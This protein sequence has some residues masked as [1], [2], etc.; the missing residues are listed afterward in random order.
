MTEGHDRMFSKSYT[1]F[2]YQHKTEFGTI[3]G[4]SE[5]IATWID[6]CP[7]LPIK[8]IRMRNHI[9]CRVAETSLHSLWLFLSSRLTTTFQMGKPKPR[10]LFIAK[11]NRIPKVPTLTVVIM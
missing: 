11:G 2:S 9:Q 4:V 5:E 6:V 1:R 10:E 8:W 7:H 3:L